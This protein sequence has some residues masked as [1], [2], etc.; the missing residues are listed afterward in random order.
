MVSVAGVQK[1]ANLAEQDRSFCFLFQY[2]FHGDQW[3]EYPAEDRL[4][5]VNVLH[6]NLRYP[7]EATG[8]CTDLGHASVTST[9]NA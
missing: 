5:R 4:V 1:D 7:P 2:D 9:R 3:A 8:C 6:G